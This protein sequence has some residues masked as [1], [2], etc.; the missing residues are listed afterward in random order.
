MKQ[1]QSMNL[2]ITTILSL[3]LLSMTGCSSKGSS[4]TAGTAGV[5][6]GVVTSVT[7]G[8][9]IVNGVSFDTTAAT[10]TMEDAADTVLKPGMVVT[11][12][13]TFD[14][15]N[16]GRANNITFGDNLKGPI[17]AF[18]NVSSS[19]TV[20][21]QKIKFSPTTVF[22]DFPTKGT[23][24]VAPG[25]MVQVS[26]FTDTD[27]T[28]QATRIERHL[29]DWTQGTIVELKGTISTMPSASSFTIG[30]LT[31]DATGVTLPSGL[32][33]GTYVKVEGTIASITSTILKATNVATYKEDIESDGSDK[34]HMELEGIVKNLSGNTFMIG[35][36]LVNAGTLPLTGISNG[37]KV[38]VIGV[39]ANG[40]LVASKIIIENATTPTTVPAVPVASV[41][42]SLNQV[43]ISWNGVN[44]ATSYNIYWSTTPGVTP[45]TG[46]KIANASSPYVQTGLTAATAYYYVITAVNSIG[47]SAPSAQVSATTSSAPTVPAAPIGVSAVGGANQ[48]TISW[49]AVDG[50]TSYNIYWSTTTG[51]TTAN[52]TKI[53]TVTS[54]FIQTGLTAATT[55]FYIVTA[56]NAVGESVPSVQV[57]ATTAS[58]AVPVAP[59]GVTA[60]G[61]SNQVTLSW[62]AVTGATSYNIY[63]STTTGVSPLT[64]TRIANATSPFVQ[65]GLAASTT[66]F[67]VVTA[68]NA[69]GES[70]PSTQ[71]SAT[72]NTIVTAPVAPTGVTA[73]GGT[74]QVAITWPTVPGATSYNLYWAT[75]T[76][77]TPAT[78]TLIAN[79]TSP[80]VQTGLAASTSYFY[81]L[82]ALNSAGSSTASA[83]VTATTAA[84]VIDGA[85]LYATNC[86]GCHGALATSSKRGRT[87]A[88]TQAAIN[89]NVGGMGFLSFL[90]PAQVAAIATALN[91]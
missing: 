77:V 42:G 11:V 21:G 27:G 81:V 1:H 75:T 53:A 83:Q 58:A 86:A 57:S 30:G 34:N 87:A 5:G 39:F 19:M 60:A 72:T 2:L 73:V 78:G 71:A 26:G 90:T 70:A 4:S 35:R 91:F 50:A 12:K 3:L 52:G 48:T 80:F 15:S 33:V 17:A 29:P 51:V 66:Y 13:G 49:A 79:V 36:T 89:G 40:I 31:I 9:V 69:S 55:Y 10:V 74:N 22:D 23:G 25:Q 62:N 28:I 38:E 32:A 43:T 88:Q 61:G 47:E 56:V 68:V 45:A 63:W 37:T 16:H 82:T 54:P 59:T 6:K 8:N 20:L 24:S 84:P 76:G 67:Y 14:D 18:S 41:F 44:S 65:T 64:G 46:T 85:A 7:T